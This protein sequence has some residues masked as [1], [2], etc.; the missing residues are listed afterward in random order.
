M[1]WPQS[2]L[3]LLGAIFTGLVCGSYILIDGIR[4]V[5]AFKGGTYDEKFGFVMSMVIM[6]VGISGV[7]KHYWW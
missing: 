3:W 1:I 4:L 5:R 2:T 6:C 7:V